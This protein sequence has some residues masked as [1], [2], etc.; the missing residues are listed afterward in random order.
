MVKSWKV[1]SARAANRLLGRS[2]ALWEREYYDRL[3]RREGE[4]DRA[5][6]YVVRNPE[7]AGLVNWKWVWAEGRVALGTAGLETGGTG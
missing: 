2:G 3:I 1:H 4:L 7:K 5:V 6:E